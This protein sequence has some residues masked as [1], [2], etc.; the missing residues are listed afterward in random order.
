LPRGEA[1]VRISNAEGELVEMNPDP[2][3]RG[4]SDHVKAQSRIHYGVSREQV[5]ERLGRFLKVTPRA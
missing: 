5:E 2:A 3:V 1:M 4:N